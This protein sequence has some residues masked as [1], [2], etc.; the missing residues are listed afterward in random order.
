[1]VRIAIEVPDQNKELVSALSRSCTL[2]TT[3]RSKDATI[4]AYELR[5]ETRSVSFGLEGRIDA[6]DR[7]AHAAR[8]RDA[9]RTL[10]DHDRHAIPRSRYDAMLDGGCESLWTSSCTRDRP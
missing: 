2:T 3:T 6:N 7:A 10:H 5:D 4:T 8:L 9:T 1:M